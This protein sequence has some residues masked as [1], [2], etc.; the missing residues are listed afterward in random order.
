MWDFQEY[1]WFSVVV[2][3][4]FSIPSFPER[5]LFTEA[6]SGLEKGSSQDINQ[7]MQQKHPVSLGDWRRLQLCFLNKIKLTHGEQTKMIRRFINGIKL[8][9]I[10][11]LDKSFLRI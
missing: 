10:K 11:M 9:Y 1:C 3:L 2:L 6:S 5:S 7:R 4:D 8:N